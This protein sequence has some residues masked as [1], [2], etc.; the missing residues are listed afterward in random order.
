MLSIFCMITV[1]IQLL[2]LVYT[3]YKLLITK[4]VILFYFGAK[5]LFLHTL[6]NFQHIARHRIKSTKRYS[7]VLCLSNYTSNFYKTATVFLNLTISSHLCFIWKYLCAFH[8]ATLKYENRQKC[9]CHV[10]SC[11]LTLCFYF[12]N[13]PDVPYKLGMPEGLAK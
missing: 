6:H 11:D 9:T 13:I 5:R 2:F 3:V 4:S 8:K 7:I 10:F 1:L 12:R